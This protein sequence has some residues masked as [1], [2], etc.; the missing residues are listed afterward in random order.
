MIKFD[1]KTISSVY[2]GEKAIEKI[3]KGTLKVYEGWK[4][5]IA[6]GVPPLTLLKSGGKDLI[7]YKLYGD[8][9][10]RGKNLFNINNINAASGTYTINNNTISVFSD[11]KGTYR[12]VTYEKIPVQ[13][14][15]N[16]YLSFQYEVVGDGKGRISIYCYDENNNF[17]KDQTFY[18][19]NTMQTPANTK[20]IEVRVY[21]N[22]STVISAEEGVIYSNIQLEVGTTATE[23]EP[24]KEPT[25]DTPIEVESVGDKT[26]NLVDIPTT[27]ITTSNK[28]IAIDLPTGKVYTLSAKIESNGVTG[29]IRFIYNLNGT[30]VYSQNAWKANDISIASG[31]EI[32]EG[33]TNIRVL[34]Q[35][36]T[37]FEGTF[38][39]IMVLEGTYTLENLPDYEPYGYKIPVKA[40]GKNVY[41]DGDMIYTKQK[42][43]ALSKE[44]KAGTYTISAFFN[45]DSDIYN[46]GL[47]FYGTATTIFGNL[48][49]DK[50]QRTSKTVTFTEN[51]T[52]LV[53]YATSAGS[54]NAGVNAS[55][56][57]IQIEKGTVATDYEPYQEPITTNIYLDEPLRKISDYAD[58]V[59]FANSKVIR[60]IRKNIITGTED[61]EIMTNNN[62]VSLY[63]YRLSRVNIVKDT[64]YTEQLCNYLKGEDV[65]TK[66]TKIGM[67]V[68]YSS[69]LIGTFFRMR[70]E[71]QY[72]D[73]ATL[74]EYLSN[75]YAN[76]KPMEY[77][78]ATTET[79]EETIELPNIPTIKGTTI[80][81]VDTTIQPSNLEVTYKGKK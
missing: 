64:I 9:V 43:I 57:D 22:E 72:D 44:I 54:T 6:S 42:S 34:L 19:N 80:L 3:Y 1:N 52:R 78:F 38:S 4:E 46:Y 30:D 13:E 26:R 11:G 53:F 8:S 39:E 16:Y 55:F 35:R 73:V 21:A 56:T 63:R 62:L 7:D 29:R 59:D 2:S 20:Y 65:T 69:S 68:Y 18:S 67:S 45:N 81:S 15:S 41:P 10:Q 48:R 27:V 17:L 71:T 58:Y 40:S 25:P 12:Q 75:L 79:T 66:D 31:F 70:T 76:G 51:I 49:Y 47:L 28:T 74:K 77:Y 61:W 50:G 14:L 23:Y 32:P 33:A 36:G 37:N 24:Y 60:Q 5:L